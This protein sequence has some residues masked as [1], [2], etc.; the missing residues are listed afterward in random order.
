MPVVAQGI[1]L[2]ECRRIERAWRQ[3]PERFL[4]RILTDRERAYCQR[5]KNPVP[6]VAGRFAAKEAVLK[7]LG[8]GWRGPISWTDIEIT[9]DEAGRP[10]LTLSGP[11]AD[12]ARQ[13]SI[14]R[15]LI[16]I[17]HTD[18]FAAATAIGLRLD[19]P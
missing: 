18:A 9:N 7:V 3:H 2:V 5:M 14:G 17:T 12:V 8:T 11:T 6:H 13:K 16:S 10:H 1:D 15:I 4:A 19:A